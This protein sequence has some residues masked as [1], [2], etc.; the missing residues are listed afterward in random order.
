MSLKCK[1]PLNPPLQKGDFKT[2][3]ENGGLFFLIILVPQLYLGTQMQR[4]IRNEAS[5]RSE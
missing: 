5:L 3:G 2:D 4:E 1:I